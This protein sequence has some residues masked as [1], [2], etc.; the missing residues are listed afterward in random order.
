MAARKSRARRRDYEELWVEE[1]GHSANTAI[2]CHEFEVC[3][4]VVLSADT[5]L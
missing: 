3:E 2:R 5:V 1:G 4:V